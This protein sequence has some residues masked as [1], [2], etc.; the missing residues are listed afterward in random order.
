M[1]S[2]RID[3]IIPLVHARRVVKWMIDSS[4]SH[5]IQLRPSQNRFAIS[6]F[7]GKSF[8][9]L[10]VEPAGNLEWL[11]RFCRCLIEEMRDMFDVQEWFAFAMNRAVAPKSSF[12]YVMPGVSSRKMDCTGNTMSLT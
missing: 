4:L 6:L 8:V 2:R 5:L 9:L 10:P 12:D 3:R 1:F 11:Y 7:L